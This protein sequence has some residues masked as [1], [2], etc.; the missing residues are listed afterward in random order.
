MQG[1]HEEIYKGKT[2]SDILKDIH[3]NQKQKE[4]QITIL[5]GELKP[6]I[7]TIADAGIIVPL[8]A[9][10]MDIAVKNDEHLVKMAAIV[11]RA[12]ATTTK[13]IEDGDY[14]Q[15]LSDEE[16]RLILDEVKLLKTDADSKMLPEPPKS[17]TEIVKD[18]T[19]EDDEIKE[20][21][22]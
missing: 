11:Q 6:L 10:Y 21:F 19:A 14:S 13:K 12:I 4:R 9:E 1:Q 15:V 18:K 20:V 7:K 8:I 3:N 17:L 22:K 16:K 2:F 5:I